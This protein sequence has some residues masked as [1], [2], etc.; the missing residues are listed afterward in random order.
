MRE[1]MAALDFSVALDVTMTETAACATYVLPALTQ[2]EK[3]ECTFFTLEFPHNVFHLRA[4][5][6][7]APDGPLGEPEIHRRLVR[8]LGALTDEDV[9]GLH[10]AARRGLDAYGTAFAARMTERPQLAGLAPVVLY[11]T[12]GP[13]LP[14]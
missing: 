13:A 8:A 3:P 12:L 4:P 1:A 14:D 11:E 5:V 7:P 2:Y 10:A 6:V 9:A